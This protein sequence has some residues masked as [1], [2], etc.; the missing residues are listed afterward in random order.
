MGPAFISPELF[1]VLPDTGVRA[2]Q[3]ALLADRNAFLAAPVDSGGLQSIGAFASLHVSIVLSGA[4]TAYLLG[5]PR[6]FMVAL[7]VYLFLT[8]AST[9]Y[10]GWHYLADDLGGVVIAI[11][12]VTGGAYLTGWRLER[13][14]DAQSV[15]VAT[16]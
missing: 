1:V 16:R 9:I 14:S 6:K 2:L 13:R 8:W 5:A 3:E 7:W 4:L 10:F 12:S 15:A 11:M